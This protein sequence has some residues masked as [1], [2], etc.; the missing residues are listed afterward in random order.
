MEVQKGSSISNIKL[1][2]F[3]L[4]RKYQMKIS[5]IFSFLLALASATSK[6]VTAE[7][8][9]PGK[10]YEVNMSGLSYS[11]SKLTIKVGDTV[12]WNFVGITHS[13]TEADKEGSCTKKPNG[14]DS[15]E[16]VAPQVFSN[17]FTAAGVYPYFCSHSVHCL[18]GMKAV[19]NVE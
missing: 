18:F 7:S 4:E 12:K 9:V 19:V 13:V 1:E 14:F 11:P 15:G 16:S 8:L 3:P 6:T 5:I 17:T 10:T 2:Q